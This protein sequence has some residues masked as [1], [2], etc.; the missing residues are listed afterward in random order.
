M[1]EDRGISQSQMV[2]VGFQAA[3]GTSRLF[4]GEVSLTSHVVQRQ[5]GFRGARGTDGG[6]SRGFRAFA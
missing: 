2:Q 4:L 5:V 1:G 6:K 3:E